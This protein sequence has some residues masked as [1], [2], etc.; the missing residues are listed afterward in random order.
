MFGAE[1]LRK[2]RVKERRDVATH[3]SGLRVHVNDKFAV[4]DRVRMVVLRPIL[5]REREPVALVDCVL[6]VNLRHAL[7]A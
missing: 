6:A 2:L 3:R 4:E 5:M 1:R 7:S